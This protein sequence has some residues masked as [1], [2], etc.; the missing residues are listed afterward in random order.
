M[1]LGQNRQSD[2]RHVESNFDM[3]LITTRRVVPVSAI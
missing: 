1:M 2:D 3:A